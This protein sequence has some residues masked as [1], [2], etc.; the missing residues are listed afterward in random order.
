MIH[1]TVMTYKSKKINVIFHYIT[2]T[3]TNLTNMHESEIF[4]KRSKIKHV[5]A[6]QAQYK[7]KLHLISTPK[8]VRAKW[9]LTDPWLNIYWNIKLRADNVQLVKIN[10]NAFAIPNKRKNLEHYNV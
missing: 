6:G 7:F 3:F 8:E 4:T 10:T 5:K 9:G 1:Y 2:I